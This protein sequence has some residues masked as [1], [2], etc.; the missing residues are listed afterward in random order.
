MDRLLKRNPHTGIRA[1]DAYRDR[2]RR[3]PVALIR[4]IAE[5]IKARIRLHRLSK[6]QSINCG[7]SDGAEDIPP[8]MWDL[9]KLGVGGYVLGRSVEKG[10][11][12]WKKPD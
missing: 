11:K 8:D 10:V 3:V 12:V 4:R 5:V 7:G 2:R 1:F 6:S 9:L